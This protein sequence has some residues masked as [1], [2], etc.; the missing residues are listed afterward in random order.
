MTRLL[1][2]MVGLADATQM[3]AE[4]SRVIAVS[5]LVVGILSTPDERSL[6]FCLNSPTMLHFCFLWS[7][8]DR[9]HNRCNLVSWSW[10]SRNMQ[11]MF[12]AEF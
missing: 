5:S 12:H 2:A 10:S 9:A 4:L 6:Q 8:I 3:L 11:A 1:G 7:N